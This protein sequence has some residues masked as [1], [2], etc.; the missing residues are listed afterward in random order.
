MSH[1]AAVETK[2]LELAE[3][4]CDNPNYQ[5]IE[6]ALREFVVEVQ[7]DKESYY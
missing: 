5:D 7:K 3:W 4:F 2:I 1:S 6:D